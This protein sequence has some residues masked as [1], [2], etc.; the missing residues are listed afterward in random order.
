LKPGKKAVV[1]TEKKEK[2]VKSEAPKFKKTVDTL[3]GGEGM[4]I[5]VLY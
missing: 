3:N 4:C 2:T 5:F 1:S